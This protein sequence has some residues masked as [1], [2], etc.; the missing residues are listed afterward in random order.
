MRYINEIFLLNMR[1]GVIRGNLDSC[2][3]GPGLE[4][5]QRGA[6]FIPWERL[7]T[8]ISSHHSCV[9]RVPD[10]LQRC[11]LS[12]QN[13]RTPNWL[14]VSSYV[15]SVAAGMGSPVKR[16]ETYLGDIALYKSSLS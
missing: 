8:H 10:R 1:I 16:F 3:D 11:L 14:P 9:K 2:S 7:F 15:L 12:P 6:K 4:S 5:A 13:G